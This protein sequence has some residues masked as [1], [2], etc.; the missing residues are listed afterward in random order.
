MDL[1]FSCPNCRQAMIVDASGAGSEVNCP[2]CGMAVKVPEPDVTNIVPHNPIAS[3]AAAR[4]ERHYSVPVREGPTE[5]LIKK[6][7]PA[8]GATVSEGPLQMRIRSIRRTDCM[9]VGHD[10]FDDKVSE[11]LAQVGEQNIISINSLAYTHLDM[12]TRQ[13]MT[14][15][16]VMIVYKG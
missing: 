12:A 1:S 6:P 3:S 11:F 16:G 5:V 14:D 4:E 9:E 2:S 7:N 15:Y 13:L 10:R 8:L